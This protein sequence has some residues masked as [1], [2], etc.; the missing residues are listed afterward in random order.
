MLMCPTKV[1]FDAQNLEVVKGNVNVENVSSFSSINNISDEVNRIADI[2]ITTIKL[3]DYEY[4]HDYVDP[5]IP[6]IP[7][8]NPLKNR[9]RQYRSTTEENIFSQEKPSG[10]SLSSV[11]VLSG[12]TYRAV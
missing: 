5:I 4:E 1:F 2:E 7:T 12:A 3:D 9:V 10:S 11:E 8:Y 6:G